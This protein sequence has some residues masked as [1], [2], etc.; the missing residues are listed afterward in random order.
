MRQTAHGVDDVDPAKQFDLVVTVRRPCPS[1]QLFAA[2]DIHEREDQVVIECLEAVIPFLGNRQFDLDDAI[3]VRQRE[4]FDRSE[5]STQRD[6][7]A[8]T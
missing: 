6:R 5:F 7:M 8:A 1:S 4:F 2:V 3:L